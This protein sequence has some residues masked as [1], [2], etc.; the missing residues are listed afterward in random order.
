MQAAE[1]GPVQG[2]QSSRQFLLQQRAQ[3]RHPVRILFGSLGGA[4]R[5]HLRSTPVD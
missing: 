2:F 3:A 5:K 4:I 1:I